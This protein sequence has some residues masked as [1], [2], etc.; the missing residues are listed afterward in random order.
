MFKGF[1]QQNSFNGVPERTFNMNRNQVYNLMDCIFWIKAGEGHSALT[2]NSIS[3]WKDL[4]YGYEFL[5]TSAGNQPRYKSS[6]AGYNGNPIVEFFDNARRMATTNLKEVR[7][8]EKWT[9]AF[10]ANYNSLNGSNILFGSKDTLT[11]DY[12]LLGGTFVSHTGAG[13]WLNNVFYGGP[14]EDSTVKI[15]V[16]SNSRLYVNG[17]LIWSGN[18]T[19]TFGLD[20]IGTFRTSTTGALIGNVAEIAIWRG[21]K[22]ENEM[23]ELSS[24]LNTKYAIY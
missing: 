16:M 10:V 12:F 14:P 2:G 11:A 20:T 19:N 8:S 4:I 18:I 24:I 7:I 21:D 23:L 15:V 5:Q 17:A 13:L 3:S 22:T 9:L 1:T 6:D